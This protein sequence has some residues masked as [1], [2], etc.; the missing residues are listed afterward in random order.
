MKIGLKKRPKKKS[1]QPTRKKGKNGKFL[2]FPFS[3]FFWEKEGKKEGKK[4]AF[5]RLKSGK[6]W[7][8]KAPTNK[9]HKRLHVT[10]NMSHSPDYKKKNILRQKAFLHIFKLTTSLWL[11]Q[12]LYSIKNIYRFA[13]KKQT[14]VGLGLFYRQK[15]EPKSDGMSIKSY[16][17][18]AAA[19]ELY[20]SGVC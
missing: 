12:K 10:S 1:S 4:K 19:W 6:N 15:T 14:V 7:K 3:L 9:I 17:P 2:K 20:A 16:H 18:S 5:A 13:L 8:K 11:E